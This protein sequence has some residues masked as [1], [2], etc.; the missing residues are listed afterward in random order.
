MGQFSGWE[1]NLNIDTLN[2][3]SNKAN[4]SIQQNEAQVQWFPSDQHG[5]FDFDP[6]ISW[7]SDVAN[8]AMQP[9]PEQENNDKKN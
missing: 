5:S 1:D 2:V 8:G 6:K 3:V 7:V 4:N 9:R